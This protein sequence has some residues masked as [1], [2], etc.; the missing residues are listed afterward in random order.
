MISIENSEWIGRPAQVVFAFVSDI[1]NDPQWHTDML[2]AEYDALGP[3]VT[4]ASFRTRFKPFMGLSEGTGTVAA[5]EPPHRVVITEKMGKFE[6][7]T[8]LTVEA[9][10]NGSRITRR[11]DMVWRPLP[12]ILSGDGTS[13]GFRDRALTTRC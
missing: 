6:P 11:M 2:E 13:W 4:G 5:Y 1:R 3:P 12:P 8:T 7:V 10:G 9:E